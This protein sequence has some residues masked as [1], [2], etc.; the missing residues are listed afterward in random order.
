MFLQADIHTAAAAAATA[1]HL[2]THM[3]NAIKTTHT[4]KTS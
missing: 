4:H 2:F 1:T 3:T